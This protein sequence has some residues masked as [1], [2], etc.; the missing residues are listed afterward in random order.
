[1]TDSDFSQEVRRMARALAAHAEWL[2]Q[3]GVSALP[4]WDGTA[5]SRASSTS[6]SIDVEEEATTPVPV[7]SPSLAQPS[8]SVAERPAPVAAEL[9]S[10]AERLSA[11]R[12]EI[13]DCRRCRL[14]EGRTKLV[15]G[16]G[17]ADARLLFVGEGPGRD[18][19]LKGEPFVGKAGQLL[20]DIIE[21]GMRL[22][23]ADVYIC[24]VVK[25]RPPD[26]RDPEP[27]EVAACGGFLERQV[28]IVGPKVIV[29]LGRFAAQALLATTTPIGRLRGRW[30]SY[31]GIP[32]MPTL[33]PAYLLRN[34]GDKRLVWED[35][36]QVMQKLDI[37]LPPSGRV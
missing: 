7:S 6:S 12:D 19:D 35:V 32:V 24:N 28:E 11:L 37:T 8:A 14:A 23:R 20:T 27:D 21:K 15:F 13:G 34:P 10:N 18:E 30:Q 4:R 3:S 36:K 31:R 1:M 26:N 29:A 22:R 33:H 9:G 2:G 17:N 5:L 25:C 16:V